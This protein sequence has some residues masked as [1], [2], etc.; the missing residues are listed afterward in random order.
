[1]AAFLPDRSA[2][3]ADKKVPFVGHAQWRRGA[4]TACVELH[5]LHKLLSTIELEETA[6]CGEVENVYVTLIK[7]HL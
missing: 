2:S 3:K 5:R 4:E 6:R 7:L 1:M